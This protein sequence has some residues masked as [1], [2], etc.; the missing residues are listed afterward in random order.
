MGKLLVQTAAPEVAA[1]VGFFCSTAAGSGEKL[2][3]SGE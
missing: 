2:G 3:G 1:I